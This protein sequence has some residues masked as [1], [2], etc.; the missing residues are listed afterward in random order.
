MALS[1]QPQVWQSSEVIQPCITIPRIVPNYYWATTSGLLLFI[2]HPQSIYKLLDLYYLSDTIWTQTV[3]RVNPCEFRPA[4]SE[5]GDSP[6]RANQSSRNRFRTP[7]AGAFK[8]IHK[9]K[10][11]PLKPGVVV[12]VAGVP[13]V[14]VE[15][16]THGV[17][18]HGPVRRPSLEV[19][20]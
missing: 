6:V 20:V 7:V 1:S 5:K 10:N 13:A 12:A 11:Q 8:L 16:V 3:I 4:L 14:A 15:V 18:E 9:W 2:V 19:L 17:A